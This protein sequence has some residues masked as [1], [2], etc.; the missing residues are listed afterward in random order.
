MTPTGRLIVVEGIDGS[1]KSSVCKLV[2]QRLDMAALII[3]TLTIKTRCAEPEFAV[4]L[5]DRLAALIWPP[6]DTSYDH[7]LPASYWLHLQA[8]WY[9]LLGAFVV[10]P[11]LDECGVL[12]MDGWFYKIVAKL[13]LRGFGAAELDTA[14]GRIVRPDAVI[15]LAPDP[16]DVWARGREFRLTELGLHHPKE[17]RELGRES[18]VHYQRRVSAQLR[19]SADNHGWSVLP[20]PA[21]ESPQRTAERVGELVR[22]LAGSVISR[23]TRQD[24]RQ[25][26]DAWR[27]K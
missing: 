4:D 26:A 14:F 7:Q 11:A 6:V 8:A 25:R 23:S 15:L 24:N 19:A 12:L 13:R 21:D 10:A 3:K 5:M 16:V 1:G 27:K 2:G 22:Q 20:V 17:Y 18:F 9:E